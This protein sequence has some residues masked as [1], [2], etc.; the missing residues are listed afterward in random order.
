MKAIFD[1]QGNDSELKFR[2]G[3]P[4]DVLYR[5]NPDTYDSDDVGPMFRIR[6]EDGYETDSFEDE[7]VI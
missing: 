4:I 5:L 1:C 6:F 3:S 7:I 2:D